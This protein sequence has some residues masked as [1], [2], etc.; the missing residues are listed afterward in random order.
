MRIGEWDTL[1]RA[2]ALLQKELGDLGANELAA[3]VTLSQE[4]GRLRIFVATDL[5]LLEYS[6]APQG[7]D[8]EGPWLLRGQLHRWSMVKALRL[9]TDAQLDDETGEV[10]SLWRLIAD[11]PKIELSADSAGVGEHSTAGL[12]PFAK[13]CLAMAN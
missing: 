6:Y 1:G 9:Q 11:D 7:S 8:P 4:S 10:R 5:G 3:H 12:L 2:R 13:A